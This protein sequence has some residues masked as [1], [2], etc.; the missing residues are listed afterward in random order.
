MSRKAFLTFSALAGLFLMLAFVAGYFT[1]NLLAPYPTRFSL[2]NEAFTILQKHSLEP[3]PTERALEY[4]MIRGMI[5]ALD[6]PYTV[7]VEPARHEL[8]S[9]DLQGSFGGVGARLARDEAGQITLFPFPEGPAAVAGVLEGDL[10]LRIDDLTIQPDTPMEEILAAIRGPLG[11]HVRLEILRPA[12]RLTLQFSIRREAVALP[13]VTWHMAPENPQVG[14]VEINILAASTPD[15]VRDAFADLQSRGASHFILDLRDNNG[16]LLSAGVDTARL[17]LKEGPIIEQQYRGA[18]V[19]SYE[20]KLPGILSDLPLVVLI[21]HNTASAAEIIAG[22]L[23][24]HGRAP[25]IGQPSFGKD[26]IQLVFD[27]HDG[28]SL[29]VT[30]AR[31]WVPGLEPPLRGHGLQPDIL[32]A[33]ETTPGDPFI[34]RAIEVL[35]TP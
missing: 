10:L 18:E 28:S 23:Q 35:L 3:L 20:V 29:H 26:T 9:N 15:E 30:A 14:V 1:H 8:E 11:T 21:N 4:G 17:F 31:W 19:E 16:G 27:L 24:R 7:F 5:Q 25:L 2:L 34:A 12:N 22:A 32:I 33:E 6:D 13:S